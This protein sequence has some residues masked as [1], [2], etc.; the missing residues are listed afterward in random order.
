LAERDDYILGG[1][2][3]ETSP[4]AEG[5]AEVLIDSIGSLLNNH[6]RQMKGCFE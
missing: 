6:I 2:E 3:V 5:A 1:Y 4:F